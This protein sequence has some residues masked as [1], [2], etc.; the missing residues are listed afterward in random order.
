LVQMTFCL[1]AVWLIIFWAIFLNPHAFWDIHILTNHFPIIPID[2][3]QSHLANYHYGYPN[4]IKIKK[5]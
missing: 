4:C 3:C 2:F 1:I 5:R